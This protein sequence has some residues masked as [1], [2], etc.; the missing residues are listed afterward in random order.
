MRSLS[1]RRTLLLS[2]TADSR[3]SSFKQQNYSVHQL[4][5]YVSPVLTNS[6]AIHLQLQNTDV[7]P[8]LS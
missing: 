6:A 4:E 7:N 2:G 3:P 5:Q 1:A 8:Y